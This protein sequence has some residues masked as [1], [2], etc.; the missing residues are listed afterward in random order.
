MVFEPFLAHQVLLKAES[1]YTEDIVAL[2]YDVCIV[3]EH[4]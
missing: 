2:H 4:R 3:E 1:L